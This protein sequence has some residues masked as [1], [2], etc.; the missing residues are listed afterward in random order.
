M[1]YKTEDE[2]MDPYKIPGYGKGKSKSVLGF[3]YSLYYKIP[4][5]KKSE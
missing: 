4:L 3:N 1:L 2:I 5:F